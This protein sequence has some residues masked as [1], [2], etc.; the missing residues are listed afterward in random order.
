MQPRS[1][2]LP[3]FSATF[4]ALTMAVSSPVNARTLKWTF[5]VTFDNRGTADGDLDKIFH[6]CFPDSNGMMTEKFRAGDPSYKDFSKESL[7]EYDPAT[8]HVDLNT[9]LVQQAPDTDFCKYPPLT[10]DV[11]NGQAC[12]TVAA[13]RGPGNKGCI[14]DSHSYCNCASQWNMSIRSDKQK[15]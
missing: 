12:I 15:P 3:L 14:Q 1:F 2:L 4:L 8:E 7:G 13:G 11:E 5:I 10:K 9:F 6:A